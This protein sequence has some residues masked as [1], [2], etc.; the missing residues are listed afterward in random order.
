MKALVTGGAGFIGTN[1]VNRLSQDGYEVT[2]LDDLS[3]KNPFQFGA[4][5]LIKVSVTNRDEVMALVGQAD[6]VFHLA[7][8]TMAL[9]IQYPYEDLEVNTGG[10]LNVI[11]AAL[12]W[13][14][15]VVYT[16]SSAVYGNGWLLPFTES[17]PVDLLTPYAAT[18]FAAECYCQAYRSAPIAIVRQSNVYGPYQHPD[19][20][21]CG[22]VAK[23][24]KRAGEGQPMIIHGDGQQTR[25]FTYV[26]DAIDAILLASQKGIGQVVNIGTGVETSI[27][28]LAQMI[29]EQF[30]FTPRRDIDLI[31]RRVLDCSKAERVLGW[32]A[33]TDLGTGLALTREWLQERVAV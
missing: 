10:M 32:Q 22:V 13:N 19:N 31:R 26:E 30:K 6:V 21:Y 18:K 24:V 14:V 16:S 8:R 20:P 33:K 23:L 2:V 3:A 12:K 17:T 15:P 27:L 7:A 29:G 11:L 9:S 5:R 1:L 4:G 28:G 25:D